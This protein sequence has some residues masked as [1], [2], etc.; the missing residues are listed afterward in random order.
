MRLISARQSKRAVTQAQISN[1][2]RIRKLNSTGS[3]TIVLRYGQHMPQEE[4]IGKMAT[5]ENRETSA[6]SETPEESHLKRYARVQESI[7]AK[8]LKMRRSLERPL[9][10]S[11]PFCTAKEL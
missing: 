7:F 10:R 5:L 9:R 2:I 11:P 8:A 6:V 1:K 4:M 3:L